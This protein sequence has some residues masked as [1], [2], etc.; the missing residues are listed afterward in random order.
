MENETIRVCKDCGSSVEERSHSGND[1]YS[2]CQG[3][4]IIE[5]ETEIITLEEYEENC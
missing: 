1:G 5:G 2:K 4:G 3:C